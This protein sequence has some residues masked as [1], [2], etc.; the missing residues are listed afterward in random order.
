MR[1]TLIDGLKVSYVKTGKVQ[2]SM[3]ICL[4]NRGASARLLDSFA[5]LVIA[6]LCWNWGLMLALAS[7]AVSAVTVDGDR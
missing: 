7:K 5:I 1:L 3:S 4:R 6:I 2:A